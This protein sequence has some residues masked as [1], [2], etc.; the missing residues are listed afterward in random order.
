MSERRLPMYRSECVDAPRPCAYVSCR[1][2]LALDVGVAG[3]LLFRH[4]IDDMR[5]DMSEEM[6]ELWLHMMPETCS[7]DVAD[8][9]QELTDH[10]V[11][12]LSGITRQ[13]VEVLAK[14]GQRKLAKS[15]VLRE[16]LK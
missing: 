9:G 4:A 11:G 1:H 7:L 14:S 12:R 10:E 5:P 16:L 13:W 15:K 6:V 3:E 2:H 8:K